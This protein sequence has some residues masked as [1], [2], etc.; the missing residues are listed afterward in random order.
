LRAI[1]LSNKG[2]GLKRAA[3]AMRH[4]DYAACNF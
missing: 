4:F 3:I 1:L 2:I